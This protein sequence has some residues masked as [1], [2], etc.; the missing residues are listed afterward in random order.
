[1][2]TQLNG[3][4]VEAMTAAVEAVERDPASGRLTWRSRVSWDGGFGLDVSVREIEQLGEAMPRRFTLRGDHPPELLGNDTGPTA[5]E[6]CLAALG[7]CMA[8]T[9]AV[10]AT[11][12]G[13]E[14]DSLEIDLE[15]DIDLNG[16]FGLRQ[17][18]PGLADVKLA[19]RV[20]S[21]ADEAVLQEVL[22]AARSLSPILDTVTRPV[23]VDASLERV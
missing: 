1:M 22:E 4:D 12:R 21:D 23:R 7:S 18:P 6:T 19:F 11:A 10:Q 8:G 9:F 17:V 3:W 16:F 20:R 14:I 2:S 15:G 13:I 5:I